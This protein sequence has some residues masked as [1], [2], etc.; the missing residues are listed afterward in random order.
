MLSF[1]AIVQEAHLGRMGKDTNMEW[2]GMLRTW[3]VGPN[4]DAI[5]EEIAAQKRSDVWQRI[6]HNVGEMALAEARGYVRVK[7]TNLIDQAVDQRVREEPTL[8]PSASHLKQIAMDAVLRQA[9]VDIMRS[10]RNV[11][12]KHEP[13]YRRA[14]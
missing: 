3:L 4:F 2:V 10:Q 6:Q 5:A 13:M 9:V 7:A 12:I 14:A 1:T 8:G 11:E